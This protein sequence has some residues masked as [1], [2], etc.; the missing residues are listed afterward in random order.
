MQRAQEAL[1]GSVQ[2][3]LS[4]LREP[5]DIYRAQGKIEGI[6]LVFGLI[7]TLKSN[8]TKLPQFGRMGR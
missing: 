4:T 1:E 3:S 7:D 5:V 2:E 6:R 8:Q